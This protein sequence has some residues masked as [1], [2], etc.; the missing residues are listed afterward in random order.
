MQSHPCAST[1]EQPN[2]HSTYMNQDET[3]SQLERKETPIREASLIVSEDLCT[4]L[5][6]TIYDIF[7][8]VSDLTSKPKRGAVEVM[9]LMRTMLGDLGSLE[10]ERTPFCVRPLDCS[11]DGVRRSLH[12]SGHV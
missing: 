9:T 1:Y 11:H 6:A 2:C 7:T 12:Y 4:A 3:L 5:P 10:Y 8:G